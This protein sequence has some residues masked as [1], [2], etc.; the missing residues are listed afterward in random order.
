MFYIFKV[1][2][3]PKKFDIDMENKQ[4]PQYV[5]INNKFNNIKKFSNK[6]TKLINKDIEKNNDKK[7]VSIRENAIKYDDKT[8][9]LY[10]FLQVITA[11]FASF[12]HG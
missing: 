3:Q 10:S 2:T 12:A 11:L 7:V 5:T 1:P 4:T 6:L 8:E 9:Q